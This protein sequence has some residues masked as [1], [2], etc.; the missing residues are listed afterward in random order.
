MKIDLF[1][2]NGGIA[3]LIKIKESW[4]NEVVIRY[5]PQSVSKMINYSK[6]R[7]PFTEKRIAELRE[8]FY[9]ITHGFF[10]AI[11]H[12]HSIGIA[13][14]AHKAFGNSYF[15]GYQKK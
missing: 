7:F 11:R 1:T 2:K 5:I 10:Y 13:T 8:Q 3:K 15:F 14:S 9:R 12:L 6:I 4:S